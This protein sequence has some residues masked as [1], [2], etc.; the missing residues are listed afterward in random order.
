MI[1]VSVC[2]TT[3]S[4]RHYNFKSSFSKPVQ[5]E[6]GYF[7]KPQPN[8]EPHRDTWEPASAI[9]PHRETWESQNEISIS[10]LSDSLSFRR[11][12]DWSRPHD[13][14]ALALHPHFPDTVS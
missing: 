4:S 6:V 11:N 5:F 12:N 8:K 9:L 13:F 1:R 14:Q 3:I 10:T 7:K 2:N